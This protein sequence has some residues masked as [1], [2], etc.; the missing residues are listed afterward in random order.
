MSSGNTV[1]KAVLLAAG[2]GKRLGHLTDH[3]PK[4][5][6]PVQG[7]PVI[8]H[9][10]VGL[11][12]EGITNFLLVVGYMAEALERYFG[13]GK[14]WGVHIEYRVQEIPNGTGA[15]LLEGREFSQGEPILASY[16]DILT[17][18]RHY[19]DLLEDYASAPCAAVIGINPMEDPSAGAAVYRKGRRIIRVVEKPPPGTAN[20]R[21]NVAGIS[22][23]GPLIWPALAALKLSPR[24]EYELTDAI[25]ALI[26]SGEEVRAHEL[27]G[28]WSDIG[29]PEALAEAER[30]WKGRY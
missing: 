18:H 27:N 29:T 24:G 4:P 2:R 26:D 16:G 28:F 22:V 3:L 9:I 17:D 23:F 12:N 30:D 5:M 6:V 13:N 1:T 20:S 19:K 14:P 11:R 25:S 8:E 7:K 21:W 15:A 10:I